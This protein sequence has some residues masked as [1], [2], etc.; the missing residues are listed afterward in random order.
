[1]DH[2]LFE[3]ADY[4]ANT[5]EER[6]VLQKKVEALNSC[7]RVYG[8]GKITVKKEPDSGRTVLRT[9]EGTR[10]NHIQPMDSICVMRNPYQGKIT[11]IGLEGMYKWM[12]VKLEG[13][14]NF[15]ED[16]LVVWDIS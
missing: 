7:F 14:G 11:A 12:T 8:N 5:P 6:I 2:S 3:K 13:P 4:N 15:K 9:T 16:Y 1:M 10:I